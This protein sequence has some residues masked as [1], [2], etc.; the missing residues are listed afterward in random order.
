MYYLVHDPKGEYNIVL[1]YVAFT[2]AFWRAMMNAEKFLWLLNRWLFLFMFFLLL[3]ACSFHIQDV[4]QLET[5]IPTT[6]IIPVSNTPT[7]VITP[8]PTASKGFSLSPLPIIIEQGNSLTSNA[9]TLTSTNEPHFILQMTPASHSTSALINPVISTHESLSGYLFYRTDN[10]IIHYNLFN[11]SMEIIW[12][13]DSNWQ[14]DWWGSFSPDGRFF[15]YWFQTGNGA[16]LWLMDLSE[17]VSNKILSIP[18][19]YLLFPYYQYPQILWLAGDQ[20]IVLNIRANDH[21]DPRN[22]AV[23]ETMK[24]YLI[25]AVDTRIIFES[26]IYPSLGCNTLAISPRTDQWSIWCYGG[27]AYDYFV[28]EADGV[29]WVSIDEPSNILHQ[30]Q[31]SMPSWSWTLDGQTIAFY[32]YSM[33]GS[34]YYMNS[35]NSQSLTFTDGVSQFPIYYPGISPQGTYVA[36]VGTC[37]GFGECTKI[38]EI[39]TGKVIWTDK[40]FEKRGM[41]IR[42]WSPD[43]KHFIVSNY[44]VDLSSGE[45]VKQ[46]DQ[47]PVTV[48]WVMP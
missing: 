25:R 43:E 21:L 6:I 36:Y 30:G 18:D 24:S 33:G 16:E 39:A 38:A 10:H 40:L 48:V 44:I 37:P 8:H 29:F 42:A 22:A 20:Y 15:A 28:I 31:L 41:F 4:H 34:L 23:E 14:K 46:L 17:K 47:A 45:I 5:M 27:P 3:V 32:T 19:L 35:S 1:N 12:V 26:A 11:D 7:I 9:I 13:A 2:Q